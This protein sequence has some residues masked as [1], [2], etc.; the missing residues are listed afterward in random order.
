MYNVL[1]ADDHLVVREGL[2]FIIETND[3][4]HVL[5]EAENG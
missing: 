4:F 1:I 2:K 5:G 3:N